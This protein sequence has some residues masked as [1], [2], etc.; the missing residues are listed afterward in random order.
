MS[1]K[2]VPEWMLKF[3]QIGQRDE[4]V[5]SS[6]ATGNMSR[7]TRELRDGS[8]TSSSK[9]PY[10]PPPLKPKEPAISEGKTDDD[11]AAALLKAA[12]TKPAVIQK[13]ENTGDEDAA[14]L[15]KTAG[16]KPAVEKKEEG[17]A[18]D[19]DSTALFKAAGEKPAIVTKDEDAAALFK[20]AEDKPAEVKKE[21]QASGDDD[22]SA[23][24]KAAGEKPVVVKAEAESGDG[25]KPAESKAD[26]TP[27][28]TKS[29]ELKAVDDTS[30]KK[31]G[32]GAGPAAQAI[33]A[34]EEQK[35]QAEEAASAAQS[36]SASAEEISIAESGEG[37]AAGETTTSGEEVTV[38]GETSTSEQ[39]VSAEAESAA[40]SSTLSR[41][42]KEFGESWVVDKNQFVE[43]QVVADDGHI[44]Y[45]DV[46][47]SDDSSGTVEEVVDEDT[48]EVASDEGSGEAVVDEDTGN[49]VVRQEGE[50]RDEAEEAET[51]DEADDIEEFEDEELDT[52][53]TQA[54]RSALEPDDGQKVFVSSVDEEKAADI[55][56]ESQGDMTPVPPPYDPDYDVENQ[57]RLL[58]E[59]PRERRSRMSPITYFFAFVVLAGAGLMT[60]FFAFG[61]VLDDKEAPTTPLAAPTPAPSAG[62]LPLDPTNSGTI[63]VAS[64]T[65]FDPIQLG[66]CDFSQL[67][68]PHVID[69][70]F[71][72]DEIAIIADDVRARY[73][74]FVS[75][76]AD[77]VDGF[78]GSIESCT[79]QNQALV[80]LSTAN[81][82]GGET[83]DMVRRQRFIL[84][85]FFFEQDGTTWRDITN[86]ISERDVCA[87]ARIT[88]DEGGVIR[89]FNLDRIGVVGQVRMVN[90]AYEYIHVWSGF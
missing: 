71:C 38:S 81:N 39:A 16:T 25:E 17:N 43:E 53:A 9:T 61:N 74:S 7:S 67:T 69:Q 32:A 44:H 76:I 70:C 10:R 36:A 5:V 3:Q 37:T 42:E 19:E 23:L 56:D 57:K 65:P 27:A 87:W 52:D 75:F 13:E 86:W 60:G 12:A 58:Q 50:Q 28:D 54:E 73:N 15:F 31:E 48:G 6:D 21:E 68:Q 82:N 83:S 33:Q 26:E 8:S 77:F 29:E 24:F 34:S 51:S 79:P 64:T 84:S 47:V 35:S 80:W 66:N 40:Q 2:H 85:Y 14:A 49:A 90:F 1:D 30:E 55:D 88:C 89:G 4:E 22:A 46:L 45:D 20:A 62:F 41:T 72:G 78:E 18:G 59:V 63:D 11:D